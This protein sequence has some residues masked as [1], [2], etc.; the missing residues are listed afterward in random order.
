MD[1]PEAF[2]GSFLSFAAL[3]T[4][5]QWPLEGL[6][7]DHTMC[8]RVPSTMPS[9]VNVSWF[10][11]VRVSIT[12]NMLA[13]AETHPD[14][15]AI[16]YCPENASD[17][18]NRKQFTYDQLK[19]HVLATAAFLQ[20]KG[21][22]EGDVVAALLTNRPS[23]IIAMLAANMIGAV[24]ASC[25]PD[26]G[27]IAVV[28]RLEQLCP[29]ALF[30]TA[31]Y[32]YKGKRFDV[33]DKTKRILSRLPTISLLV[34]CEDALPIWERGLFSDVSRS[35]QLCFLQSIMQEQACELRSLTYYRYH[36]DQPVLILFT[37][38]TT[39]KPKALV[40]GPG[41]FLNHLKVT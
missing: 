18:E 19:R 8:R 10:P 13:R 35:V 31:G 7:L 1:N 17:I 14:D 11:G 24:F 22:R 12:E 25:S 36:F 41:V 37:S 4:Q 30:V 33:T 40:H 28:D 32:T 5:P 16:V 6:S 29:T 26:L 38:G 2:W 27:E 9:L 23:A 15:V 21:I 39:G 3:K 20:S 34:C